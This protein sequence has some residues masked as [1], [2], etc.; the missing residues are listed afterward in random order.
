M[1]FENKTVS[2]IKEGRS[3]RFYNILSRITQVQKYNIMYTNKDKRC[4]PIVLSGTHTS[5]QLTDSKNHSRPHWVRGS[6]VV[7][8][9]LWETMEIGSNTVTYELLA[10]TEPSSFSML[11]EMIHMIHRKL[12]NIYTW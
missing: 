7:V 1:I 10:N 6:V 3:P 5:C 12:D 8:V 9:D 11:A 4:I 2:S